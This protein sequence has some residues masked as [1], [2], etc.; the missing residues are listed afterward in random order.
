MRL[1]R[2]AILAATVLC[3]C[4]GAPTSA[5]ARGWELPVDG[6][7]LRPFS[8]GPDR[9]APGQHRGVDLTAPPGTAVRAACA[10]RVSFA[11][12]V[13]GGGRTVSVRCGRLAATYQHLGVVAVRRGQVVLAR[14]R[15]GTV[16][17][18][19]PRPH[20][21]LGA[22]VA[23]TGT[24][25][26]PLGLLSRAP[27]STPP[28]LPVLRRAPPPAPRRAPLRPR[29]LPPPAPLVRPRSVP[30]ALPGAPPVPHALPAAAPVS[31]VARDVGAIPWAL[32]LG[33]GLLALGLPL[34][35]LVRV[36]TRRRRLRMPAA[37]TAT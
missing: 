37:R 29:Y 28:P 5:A 36:R 35:G 27:R 2:P 34:G 9:Y 25:L 15:I 12:R 21:H 23:A 31:R 19:Q 30:H 6:E 14:S 17:S 32:W 18:P 3:A 26:D 1:L 11:G 10:G 22:R 4:A 24:Y 16:G 8:I 20:V 33:L 13:P 7:V